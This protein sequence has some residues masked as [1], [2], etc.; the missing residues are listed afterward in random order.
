MLILGLL[1]GICAIGLFC[2]LI[3]N[4]AIYALPIF[5]G[6]MTGI[7]AYHGGSG[8]LG[9]VL[10]G[11]AVGAVT[12]GAGQIAFA[13]VTS[14]PLRVAIAATFAIPAAIVGYHAVLELSQLGM[15]TL[16]WRE[17][18]AWIGAMAV[19]GTAWAR[20]GVLVEPHPVQADAVAAERPHPVLTAAPRQG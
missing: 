9:A 18:L 12:L 6:L 2:W 17:C 13:L 14:V 15:S 20:L 5:V 1:L 19:G 10:I 16:F 8:S 7:A 11:I 3:F 4:L